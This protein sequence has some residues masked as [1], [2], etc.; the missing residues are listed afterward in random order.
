MV[1]SPEAALC[2]YKST[3]KP[4]MDTVIKSG[5]VL[6]RG[7]YMELLDKL[8]KRIWRTVVPSLAASLEPLAH[9]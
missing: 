9:C 1:F 5:I 8:Q 6:A 3:I 7:C 4:F 2:L